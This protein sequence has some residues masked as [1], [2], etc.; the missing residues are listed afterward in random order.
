MAFIPLGDL[1]RK[2][3]QSRPTVA[4]GVEASQVVEGATALLEQ[5]FPRVAIRITVVSFRDATLTVHAASGAA[6]AELRLREQR[7]L[8]LLRE[9]FG[10]GTVQRLRYA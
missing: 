9:K 2:N 6:G 5:H 1:L 3:V 10:P 7:Y 4:R 8:G